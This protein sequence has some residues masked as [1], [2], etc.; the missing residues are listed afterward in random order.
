[1]STKLFAVDHINEVK[2]QLLKTLQVSFTYVFID[3][4]VCIMHAYIHTCNSDR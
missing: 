2:G 3:V 1:M 4:R